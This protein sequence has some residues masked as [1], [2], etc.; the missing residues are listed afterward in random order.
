VGI[1]RDE[2]GYLVKGPDILFDGGSAKH[3]P[4]D[5]NPYYLETNLPGVFAAGDVRQVGGDQSISRR[6]QTN[7]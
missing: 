7:N 1:Q 5:R 4:M 3:W 6:S 2:S